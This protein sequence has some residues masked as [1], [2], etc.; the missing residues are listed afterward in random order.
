MASFVDYD[1]APVILTMYGPNI[2]HS[3]QQTH[4]ITVVQVLKF[5]V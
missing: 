2:W 5:T 3:R 1:D 4:E